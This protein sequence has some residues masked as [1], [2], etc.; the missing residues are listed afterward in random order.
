MVKIAY[1][2]LAHC[3][4]GQVRRLVDSL[5]GSGDFFIH[6]DKKSDI[7]PFRD[8]LVDRSNVFFLE[9]RIR[10]NWAAWSVPSAYLELLDMAYNNPKHYERFVLL[11]GQ[12]YPIMTNRQILEEFEAHSD[13]EYIMAY[14]ISHSTIPTD[15]NKILRRWYFENPFNH[16][17]LRRCWASFHYRCI[18]RFSNR[19]T[20]LVPLN[21]RLVEPYFGQM[22]SAFTRSAAKLLTHV[23]R[24]DAEYNKVMKHVHAPDEEYWHTVIFNSPLRSNT[25][26]GGK[27]HEVCE[28]FGFAPLHFHTYY[29]KCSEYT[30]EDYEDIVNSGYMF[31]RK[32]I[33]GKSDELMDMIDLKRAEE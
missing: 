17:L 24:T 5:S 33:P 1:L 10:V 21:G 11:T 6:I 29:G 31:F 22:L 2:L 3:D 19:K 14:Q 8:A 32:A 28:K 27:E 13:T 20:L 12:D 4:P 25:I 16:K 30:H 26:Q 9:D 18:T 15:K 23:Y 7:E